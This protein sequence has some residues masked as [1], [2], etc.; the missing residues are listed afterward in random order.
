MARDRRYF[1]ATEIGSVRKV[2]TAFEHGLR[3]PRSHHYVKQW[4]KA[5][6]TRSRSQGC[7]VQ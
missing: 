5:I 4:K 1:G 2:L 3:Y 7:F 6:L